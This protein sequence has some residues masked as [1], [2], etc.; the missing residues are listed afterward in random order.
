MGLDMYLSKRHYVQ[1]WDHIPPARQFDVTVNR[2]G[3]PYPAI[4]PERVKYVIEQVAYWRKAN[5]I[6]RWF[7][8]NCQSGEDDCKEYYVSRDKLRELLVEVEK[9]LSGSATGEDTLPTERG[10]FFGD[11]DYGDAYRED[12]EETKRQIAP[13]LA[14]EHDDN[15]VADYYYRASW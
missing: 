12:L 6:H 15:M 11:T 1:R 5:A 7:V 9:I 13:L 2:G 4:K 14:D 3:E 8:E 10:F